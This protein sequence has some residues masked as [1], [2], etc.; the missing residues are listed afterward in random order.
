MMDFRYL[1]IDKNTGNVV[2][3]NIVPSYLN[4]NIY[5]GILILID[6]ENY[7]EFDPST[8]TWNQI[9]REEK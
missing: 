4:Y 1:I 8:E 9:D 3:Y 2:R 5:K 7:T 6:L